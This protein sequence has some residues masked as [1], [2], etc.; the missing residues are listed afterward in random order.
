MLMMSATDTPGASSRP[1]RPAAPRPAASDDMGHHLDSLLGEQLLPL[2]GRRGTE[3]EPH[4]LA[5]D[6]S[7]QPVVVEVVGLLDEAALSRALRHAGRAARLSARDLAHAYQGGPEAFADHLAAFRATVP[8]SSLLSPAVRGG[9]RLLLVC[10]GVASSAQDA[11][12][13]LLQAGWQVEVLQ[14]AL[15]PGPDGGRVLDVTPL[16]AHH[17]ARAAVEPFN[18]RLVHSTPPPPSAPRPTA[19]APWS[20]RPSWPTPTADRTDLSNLS[21]PAPTVVAPTFAVP[22]R[23]STPERGVPAARPAPERAPAARPAPEERVPAREQPR[24]TP[25]TGQ[26][27]DPLLA[28]LARMIGEPAVLVWQRRRGE[29]FEALLHVSGLV[30]LPD[31]SVHTHP[32]GA[33][34]AACGAPGIDG[35]AVWRLG[36]ITG[37]TLAEAAQF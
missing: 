8:A 11:V 10:S 17:P 15:V 16:T 4:L 26:V 9:S 37:P 1:T 29:C 18:L 2:R 36:D 6:A 21:R 22:A 12:E 31:G 3:D 28:V 32:D 14:V 7:G 24:S 33:A 23:P 5:V 34:A 19:R 27:P 30:E 20:D 25:P 35:W 13:F